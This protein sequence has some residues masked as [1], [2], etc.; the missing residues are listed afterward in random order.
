M[1]S[2]AISVITDK[3]AQKLLDDTFVHWPSAELLGDY[4]SALRLL[5]SLKPEAFVKIAN[6]TLTA[7][8]AKQTLATD[9]TQLKRVRQWRGTG[10]T[11][12]GA[13]VKQ[14]DRDDL[15]HN[16]PNWMTTVG[17]V[18]EGYIPDDSDPLTFYVYPPVA[19]GAVE[20]EYFAAPTVATATSQTVPVADVY[21][22]AL[23]CG[24]MALAHG[25]S[26]KAGDLARSD[27]WMGQMMAVLGIQ[28]TS[29]ERTKTRAAM[30]E[31]I[32]EKA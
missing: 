28:N 24:V 15:D 6:H 4:N 25:K 22:H 26:T 27:Y 1:G 2:L 16:D 11:T 19:A 20:L 17:A 3:A 13:A 31:Q 23:L 29:S 30:V 32:K 18:V 10:G 8:R 12:E 7:N 14:M 5:A 21:A 9:G